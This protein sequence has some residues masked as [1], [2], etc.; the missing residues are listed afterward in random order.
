[1]ATF[2]PQWFPEISMEVRNNKQ[3]KNKITLNFNH[4]KFENTTATKERKMQVALQPGM[5]SLAI[6]AV[7][8][9]KNQQTQQN[10]KPI[11]DCSK[12]HIE[13]FF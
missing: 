6:I 2:A 13:E 4:R 10:T 3:G 8:K 12:K 5:A 9:T 7:E 1:M 11:K